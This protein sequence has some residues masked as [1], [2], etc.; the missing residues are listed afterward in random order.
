MSNDGAVTGVVLV[1]I[2]DL[3]FR[4]RID[5]VARRLGVPLR[6]AKSVTQLER[7]LAAGAPAMAI[8]DLEIDTMDPAETVTR[9]RNAAGGADTRLIAFAGHTNLDA[10]RA[11]RAAGAGVVLAR[12]AFVT[13]LP[14]LLGRMAEGQ[15]T[16][17]PA[18]S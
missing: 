2:S 9:I 14:A 7:H 13:Q 10:I 4:S 15:R 8:V 5:D 16:A 18:G 6:V 11:G 17:P 3:L 12:S 1:V